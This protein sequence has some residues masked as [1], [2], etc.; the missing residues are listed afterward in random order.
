[1]R[2]RWALFL[3]VAVAVGSIFVQEGCRGRVVSAEPEALLRAVVARRLWQLDLLPCKEVT[4]TFEYVVSHTIVMDALSV[5]E[6]VMT[7]DGELL[8]SKQH[9]VQPRLP[10]GSRP[11]PDE[12]VEWWREDHGYLRVSELA[13]DTY[14]EA[15]LGR[16]VVTSHG[17]TVWREVCETEYDRL[18]RDLLQPW[19]AF[20]EVARRA[21]LLRSLAERVGVTDVVLLC[22]VIVRKCGATEGLVRSVA[23]SNHLVDCMVMQEIEAGDGRMQRMRLERTPGF[24]SGGW[25]FGM[26]PKRS[27][28]GLASYWDSDLMTR[29]VVGNRGE[30]WTT[31]T[32]GERVRSIAKDLAGRE[33]TVGEFLAWCDMP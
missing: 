17:S 16:P 27:L 1:M 3:V 14:V 30:R 9:L 7:L 15:M 26:L 18:V 11:V 19:L 23:N 21:A 28:R 8:P 29:Y 10:T 20:S 12:W 32:L 13:R 31:L 5:G 4:V 24:Y 33:C 2:M 6:E 22:D 25:A